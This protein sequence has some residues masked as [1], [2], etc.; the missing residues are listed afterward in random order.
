MTLVTT[1]IITITITTHHH[2]HHYATRQPL[3]RE[4]GATVSQRRV[5]IGSRISHPGVSRRMMS[6]LRDMAEDPRTTLNFM[7]SAEQQDKPVAD[8]ECFGSHRR[9]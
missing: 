1:T 8:R 4:A 9:G 7:K 2:H 3:H 6:M 5:L